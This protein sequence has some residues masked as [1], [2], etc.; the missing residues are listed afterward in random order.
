MVHR[1]AQKSSP[2]TYF[3]VPHFSCSSESTCFKSRDCAA[4]PKILNQILVLDVG[5]PHH[6]ALIFSFF[7]SYIGLRLARAG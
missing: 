2:I 3:L 4:L 1:T 5:G 7:G 6:H